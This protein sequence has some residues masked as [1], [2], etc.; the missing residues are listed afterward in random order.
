[1]VEGRVVVGL[2][3]QVEEKKM[4]TPA[5]WLQ[6]GPGLGVGSNAFACWLVVCRLEITGTF[7]VCVS[8]PT[9]SSRSVRWPDGCPASS[10][11]SR[12]SGERGV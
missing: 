10:A 7:V 1:M 2:G 12:C 8:S 11:A 9:R 5:A 6:I 3:V 4:E